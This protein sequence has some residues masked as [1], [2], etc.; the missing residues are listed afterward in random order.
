[1]KTQSPFQS[2]TLSPT[3]TPRSH[4]TLQRLAYSMQS[5]YRSISQSRFVNPPLLAIYLLVIAAIYIFIIGRNRY[6]ATS[7]FVIRQPLPPSTTGSSLLSPT[8]GSPSILGSLEDGRYLQVYLSSP[9]VMKRIYPDISKLQLNYNPEFPDIFSGLPKSSNSDYQLYFF[10]RQQSVV[11]QELSGVI[12]LTTTGFT[13]AQA[14]AL[15]K[16]LLQ[17]AQ[18]F[19]NSVNQ[20]IS[21]NQLLFAEKEVAKARQRLTNATNTLNA[22]QDQHGQLNAISEKELTSNFSTSLE[23]R[24]VDL[25]VQEATLRRQFRDPQAPEVAYV[26]DQARELQRQIA[27]ERRDAV[28]SKGRDLNEMS[29]KLQNLQNEVAFASEALKSSLLASDNSRIESQ[30]QIK[31]LV[32]L[33]E[34]RIPS[35]PNQSWRFQAFFSVIG[36]LI[37]I[38]GVGGF[39]VGVS[40]RQ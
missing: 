17:Q 10:R 14:F 18:L 26:S 20:G 35:Q 1:M 11:P 24:L 8:L 21:N 16:S 40:R 13:S 15:N 23:S 3:Q 34:P 31:Y 7:E 6:T 2:K 12:V 22:F 25:K 4:I 33:Q 30:R 38:W 36:I 37:V 32:M 28:S 5:T 39:L 29:L 19:V 27:E 9:E